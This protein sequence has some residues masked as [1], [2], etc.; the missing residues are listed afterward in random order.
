M[1]C[2]ALNILLAGSFQRFFPLR[3]Q[4]LQDQGP[5]AEDFLA[6]CSAT[7]MHEP[8]QASTRRKTA[9]WVSY[10]D[11]TAMVVVFISKAVPNVLI[12]PSWEIIQWPAHTILLLTD[13]MAE[14]V[15]ELAAT[16]A[17]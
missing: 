13:S 9:I 6:S 12:V 17:A 7:C 5:H 3:V 15:A 4:G 2:A 1:E 10:E 11:L 8:T 16:G 14:R